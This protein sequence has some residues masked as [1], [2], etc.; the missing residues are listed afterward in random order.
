MCCK[1]SLRPSFGTLEASQQVQ[2][3]SSADPSSPCARYAK[4]PPGCMVRECRDLSPELQVLT[5]IKNIMKD[6]RFNQSL[7]VRAV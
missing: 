6:C 4:P 7:K 1:P 3:F 5:A 2:E